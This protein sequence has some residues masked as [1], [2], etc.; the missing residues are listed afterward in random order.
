MRRAGQVLRRVGRIEGHLGQHPPPAAIPRR[1]SAPVAPGRG[2][3]AG[4]GRSWPPTAA[5]RT[6]GRGAP[7]RPR[8]R[9]CAARPCK[10]ST[11][12]GQSPAAAGGGFQAAQTA[13]SPPPRQASSINCRALAGPMPGNSG[14]SRRAG[15]HVAGVLGQPEEGQQVL[16]VGR[17]DELQA[18]VLVEGDFPPGQL[19]LQQHAVVRGAEQHRLPPQR[20]ARLAVLQDLPDD[21]FGLLVLVLA[22]RPS[23]GRCPSR[24]L[25]T[26]GSSRSAPWPGAM[27]RLVA[28]RIGPRAAVVLLQ[29]DDGRVRGSAWGSRGCCGPWRR[30]TSRSTGRRRPPRSGPCPSGESR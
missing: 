9:P 11:S 28:S 26:R 15:D 1:R 13:K 27:T 19:G 20:D 21:V 16:D 25:A 18:A 4:R 14:S 2:A 30:G 8:S 24:P 17:L 6:S 10:S 3:A 22:G 29:R 23:T 5:R 12:C 7:G